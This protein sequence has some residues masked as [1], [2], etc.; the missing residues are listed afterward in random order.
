MPQPHYT[1]RALSAFLALALAVYP[2]LPAK[3]QICETTHTTTATCGCA[4][5]QMQGECCGCCTRP[6]PTPERTS[7]TDLAR[8]GAARANLTL[9]SPAA[10]AALTPASLQLDLHRAVAITPAEGASLHAQG[11]LLLI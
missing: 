7:T 9:D 10:F 2:A 3:T 5:G 8:D 6:V 11:I 1:V 4:T